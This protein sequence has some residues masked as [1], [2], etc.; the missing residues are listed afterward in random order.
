MNHGVMS[1]ACDNHGALRHASVLRHGG[2]IV[3][4][5]AASRCIPRTTIAGLLVDKWPSTSRVEPPG[6]VCVERQQSGWQLPP[7]RTRESGART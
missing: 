4:V 7:D 3:G 5:K 1:L 2:A 6:G